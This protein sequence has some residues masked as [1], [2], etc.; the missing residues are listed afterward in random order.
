MLEPDDVMVGA[1]KEGLH[2]WADAYR[3]EELRAA[4]VAALAAAPDYGSRC[5]PTLLQEVAWFLRDC[6]DAYVFGPGPHPRFD[7]LRR[8]VEAALAAVPSDAEIAAV[9][10][11]ELSNRTRYATH[12]KHFGV[13]GRAGERMGMP[14]ADVAAAEERMVGGVFG[15]RE[16]IKRLEAL[17]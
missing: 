8:D 2:G 14:A 1:L 5:M 7:G 6:E 9:L 11:D 10:I 15:P 16:T 12:P 3:E 17:L 13:Y 4:L